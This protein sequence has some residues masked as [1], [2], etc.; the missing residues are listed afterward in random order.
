MCR[1]LASSFARLE[2]D[3]RARLATQS[4]GSSSCLVSPPLLSS[5]L[6]WLKFD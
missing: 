2:C 5:L 4:A 3:I 1:W 6:S